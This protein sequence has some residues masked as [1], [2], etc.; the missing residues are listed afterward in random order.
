MTAWCKT[1]QMQLNIEKCAILRCT[2]S[3]FP[4]SFDYVV[5]GKTLTSTDKHPYLGITLH[6]TT[7]RSH[8]IDIVCKKASKLLNFIRRNLSRCSITVKSSAYLTLVR[9]M[10]EYAASVWDPHQQYLIDNIINYNGLPY[11]YVVMS[12]DFHR[13]IRSFTIIVLLSICHP[14]TCQHHI[15][16]DNYIHIGILFHLSPP[17]TSYHAAKFLSQ[18]NQTV[19]QLT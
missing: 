19:E 13:F 11:D 9:P 4:I 6:K 18:I 2:R 8:H 5:D 12:Q 17:C 15:Q 1:W 3:P 10:M 7:Q 14:T 16:P